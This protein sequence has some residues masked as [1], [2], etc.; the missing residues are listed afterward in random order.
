MPNLEI[1]RKFL[2][3]QLEDL[4]LAGHDITAMAGKR[5]AQGYLVVTGRGSLR[6]RIME[7]RASL[8]FKGSRTGP[9]RTEFETE[10][11]LDIAE[12]LMV[13]C[14]DRTLRKTRYAVLH[15]GQL[16]DIDVFE[17]QNQG[18]ILAEAELRSTSAS[19]SIPNWCSVEVTND[20]RFYNQYL[21]IGR[22]A[23]WRS[24]CASARRCGRAG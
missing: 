2:V 6:V 11:A 24:G 17:G 7:N 1:E 13:L 10:I 18:L 9:V 19:L 23:S 15:E 5:I 22:R 12:Q 16:W 14:D 21:P 8:T 20:D 3:L 4:V